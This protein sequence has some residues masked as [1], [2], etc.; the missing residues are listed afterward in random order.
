MRSPRPIIIQHM[1]EEEKWELVAKV[2]ASVNKASG[3]AYLGSGAEQSSSGK[4]F[5]FRY[6]PVFSDIQFN[7]QSYR[8]IYGGVI[9]TIE[10][11]DDYLEKHI[12]I[13][14][15]GVSRGVKEQ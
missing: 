13:R 12:S 8:I 9:Y 3:N 15:L 1:N 4:T 11:Y 5:T 7:K 2:H 6:S 14:L 10:D